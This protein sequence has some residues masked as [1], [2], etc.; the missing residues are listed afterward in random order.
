MPF[1]VKLSLAI[2][3]APNP[4]CQLFHKMAAIPQVDISVTLLDAGYSMPSFQELD[5]SWTFG[6]FKT[7]GWHPGA[8][9][10]TFG[11]VGPYAHYP[12]YNTG[13]GPT[14]ETL[15]NLSLSQTLDSNATVV[16]G[17]FNQQG[18]FDGT[19]F[20][21]LNID[22]IFTTG[23]I[24]AKIQAYPGVIDYSTSGMVALSIAN[25]SP[26]MTFITCNPVILSDST[27][28]FAISAQANLG[29]TLPPG[30]YVLIIKPD[31]TTDG[32]QQDDIQFAFGL[33]ATST[34]TI[35]G[36]NVQ[37]NVNGGGTVDVY[38]IT[39]VFGSGQVA[40]LV[41]TGD[42]SSDAANA[43]GVLGGPNG[44]GF[45]ITKNGLFGIDSF[46]GNDTG[47]WYCALDCSAFGSVAFVMPDAALGPSSSAS[48]WNVFQGGTLFGYQEFP[49]V[50]DNGNWWWVE[51][52]L[53]DG[54]GNVIVNSFT[55]KVYTTAVAS[56][57]LPPLYIDTSHLP[58][59]QLPFCVEK[60]KDCC[61]FPFA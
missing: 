43:F 24:D 61:T 16:P 30:S 34:L 27:Q 44:G 60:D 21:V 32:W 18:S 42:V 5:L 17:A 38:N 15:V 14:P 31:L 58:T 8:G 49:Q 6:A 39:Y 33:F 10:V 51:L 48:V 45:F 26:S 19:N 57:P 46:S 22:A 35:N 59:V 23:E 25:Q 11:G 41:A 55:M 13:F 1:V 37:V 4:R 2:L 53:C 40:T 36:V 54:G 9:G 12:E 50:D 3:P 47:C 56:L 52:P 20:L 7:F 28:A 29:A